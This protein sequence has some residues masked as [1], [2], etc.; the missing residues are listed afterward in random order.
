AEF[1]A[2]LVRVFDLVRTSLADHGTVWLNCGDTYSHAPGKRKPT[3]KYGAKQQT[4]GYESTTGSAFAPGIDASNLCLIPWRLAI[5]L[6]DAG[7]IVR[8]VIAWT[9]PSAMPASLAGW[10]WR[11]CR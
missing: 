10:M 3:D 7:W 11:R 9:K 6:Q 1:V 4:N 8:S 2:N 5:A